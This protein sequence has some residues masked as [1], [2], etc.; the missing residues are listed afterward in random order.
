MVQLVPII[1]LLVPWTH[2]VM[3]LMGFKSQFWR[4]PALGGSLCLERFHG[5]RH[6]FVC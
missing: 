1:E 4:G 3:P 2:D 6:G 5:W